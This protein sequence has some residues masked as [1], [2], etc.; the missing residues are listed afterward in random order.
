MAFLLCKKNRNYTKWLPLK[1]QLAAKEKGR[2]HVPSGVKQGT[3]GKIVRKCFEALDGTSLH[4][5]I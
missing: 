4:Q 3:D 2:W 5:K 1:S